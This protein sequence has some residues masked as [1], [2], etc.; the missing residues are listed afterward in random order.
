[1]GSSRVWWSSVVSV[2]FAACKPA[3]PCN[4]SALV[5][6]DGDGFSVCTDGSGV[7]PTGDDCDD[8]D[9]DVNPGATEDCA[10]G[11]DNDCDG[12]SDAGDPFTCPTDDTDTQDTGCDTATDTGCDD[13][14]DPLLIDSFSHECTADSGDVFGSHWSYSIVVTGANSGGLV[15]VDQDTET[16]FHEEH[17]LTGASTLLDVDL[18]GAHADPPD[19]E[20]NVSTLF[21]CGME[22]LMVWRYEVYPPEGGDVPSDCVVAS[23]SETTPQSVWGTDLGGC[24]N[25]NDW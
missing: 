15:L 7:T 22:T 23:G 9:A 2:A 10:D 11:I 21:Q 8:A 3:T 6:G 17:D 1:M 19:Q 14:P 16:P 4:A 5:D 25:G 24:A 18:V 13:P 20:A 12:A